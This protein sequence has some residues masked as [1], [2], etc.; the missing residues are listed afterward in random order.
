LVKAL[1]Q[2]FH[3]IPSIFPVAA[4]LEGGGFWDYLFA[5]R[6]SRKIVQ[7][8][9]MTTAVTKKRIRPFILLSMILS[10]LGLTVSGLPRVNAGGAAPQEPQAADCQSGVGGHIFANGGDLEVE[11]LPADAGFTIELR[12]ISPGPQRV[13]ATNRDAGTIVKLGSYPA[14]VELIFGIF[15]RDTQMTYVMGSGAGNP[16]GLPHAEVTCFAGKRSNI[17]FEDQLGGGDKDY[18]DLLCTVR[19]PGSCAFTV[20][21]PSQSYGSGGG[22]GTVNV[23]T[24]SGCSWGAVSSVN[25][26]TITSGASGSDS[27]SVGYS[28][29]LNSTTGS[30]TGTITVQGQTF[31]VFQDAAGTAPVITNAVREGKKLMIYGLNFDGGSVILLNDEKQKTVYDDANPKTLLIGKKAGK[32]AQPGDKIRVRNSAGDLSAPYTY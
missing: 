21:P 22:A 3:E 5:K 1:E 23:G 18:N 16:D 15:V 8:R 24:V 28:V 14:G 4:F 17:G 26:V 10:F 29:A 25:W 31:T 20:S 6:D 7:E 2:E 27:G 12:L 30:R 9:F 11:I 19:Q 13:L 32:W